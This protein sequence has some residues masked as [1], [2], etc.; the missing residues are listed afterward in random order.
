V[1]VAFAP[2][3]LVPAVQPLRVDVAPLALDL[4]PGFPASGPRVARS[5]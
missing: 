2:L 4:L 5:A 3:R 1:S